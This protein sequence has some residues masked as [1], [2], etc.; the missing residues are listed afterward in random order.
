[1]KYNVSLS[2]SLSPPPLMLLI[3]T[4]I[5]ITIII[6]NIL[7]KQAIKATQLEKLQKYSTK[8]NDK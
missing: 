3:V 8:N 4:I 6:G 5:I 2:S 1:M 7:K